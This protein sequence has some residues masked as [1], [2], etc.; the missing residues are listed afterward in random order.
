MNSAV[1]RRALRG[2]IEHRITREV[3][4]CV[5]FSKG[6]AVKWRFTSLH[7]DPNAVELT[8]NTTLSVETTNSNPTHYFEFQFN[9]WGTMRCRQVHEWHNNPWEDK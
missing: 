5:K 7:S 4:R 1:L 3:N 8:D 9:E 6:D 2:H